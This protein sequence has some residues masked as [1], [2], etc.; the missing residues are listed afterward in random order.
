MTDRYTFSK[1]PDRDVVRVSFTVV[2]ADEEISLGHCVDEA[3]PGDALFGVSY[4]AM[5]AMVCGTVLVGEDG[6]VSVE[7]LVPSAERR[8]G[9]ADA[10]FYTRPDKR[11]VVLDFGA[12]PGDAAA[13]PGPI[14]LAAAAGPGPI[15]LA[16]A[17][18]SVRPG[19]AFHG[20]GYDALA[21]LGRGTIRVDDDGLV[22]IHPAPVKGQAAG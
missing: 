8:P 13:G 9:P 3:H 6:E 2:P 16:A 12:A 17:T 19:Q 21:A 7:P 20:I 22:T 4:A 11:A 5:A 10:T 18:G 1:R 15:D 14:D